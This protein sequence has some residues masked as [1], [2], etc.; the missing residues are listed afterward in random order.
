MG[1]RIGSAKE[2][3]GLFIQEEKSKALGVI[4]LSCEK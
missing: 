1:K 3:D 4:S 2:M